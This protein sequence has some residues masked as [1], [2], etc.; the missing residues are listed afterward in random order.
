MIFLETFNR[1]YLA[2]CEQCCFSQ[3]TFRYCKS[4]TERQLKEILDAM[5]Q[6]T[7]AVRE[8]D[9]SFKSLKHALTFLYNQNAIKMHRHG[10]KSKGNNAYFNAKNTV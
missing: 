6:K 7:G 8:G 5:T 10:L 1:P 4:A 9:C 2:K 3:E